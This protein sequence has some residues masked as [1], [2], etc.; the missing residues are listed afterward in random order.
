MKLQ[1]SNSMYFQNIDPD[2]S[3]VKNKQEKKKF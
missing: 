3:P 2:S 1:S